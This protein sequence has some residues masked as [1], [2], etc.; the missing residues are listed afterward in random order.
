MSTEVPATPPAIRATLKEG[1]FKLPDVLKS[2]ARCSGKLKSV[3]SLR[4]STPAGD[5]V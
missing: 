5:M 2:A 1:S 3:A 4:S